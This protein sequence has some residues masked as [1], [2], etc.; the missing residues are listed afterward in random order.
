L[1]AYALNGHVAIPEALPSEPLRVENGP[2][3]LSLR[4]DDKKLD[5]TMRYLEEARLGGLIPDLL[6]LRALFPD[7]AAGAD[8]A[9]RRRLREH[10]E[11]FSELA[12]RLFVKLR[13]PEPN[14]VAADVETA[15]L[16]E[17][18]RDVLAALREL[19]VAAPYEA[20][21]LRLISSLHGDE[22]AS[23][24]DALGEAPLVTAESWLATALLLGSTLE[25]DGRVVDDIGAYRAALRRELTALRDLDTDAFLEAVLSRPVDAQLVESRGQALRVLAAQREP[26]R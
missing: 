19:P 14:I 13:L 3:I 18:L 21:G 8:A 11:R 5:W 22:L 25:S 17:S 16:R 1:T 6:L 7:D 15:A 24:E 20:D 12:D 9:T 10:S 2:T 23:A 4:L 26:A